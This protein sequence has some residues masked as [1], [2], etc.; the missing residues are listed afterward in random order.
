MDER[1]RAPWHPLEAVPIAVLAVLAWAVL[2]VGIGAFLGVGGP[3]LLLGTIAYQAALAVATLA[4]VSIRYRAGPRSLGLH[5]GRGPVEVVLGAFGGV[6]LYGLVRYA[7]VPAVTVMWEVVLRRPPDPP[8]QLP[9]DFTA[10]EVA[11]GVV[12]VVVVAPVAEEIFFRGFLY[13]G[14]R[15]R[16]GVWVSALISSA[17]FGLAHAADGLV[18][19]PVLFV[20]GLG[21][22]L[23]YERRGALGA[24]IAA[25]AV[26]NIVGFTLI[27]M[28][29]T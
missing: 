14:L 19:V 25:H 4:W 3:A 29:R 24:S 28:E 26:F 1:L 13:G 16:F 5:R 15:G 27:L 11:L 6:L 21:L 18:L 20:V 10:V 17:L 8:A 2:S 22:A 9:L 23:L 7:V 12:S